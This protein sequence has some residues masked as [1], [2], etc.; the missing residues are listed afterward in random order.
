MNSSIRS[1]SVSAGT[2]TTSRVSPSLQGRH[3]RGRDQGRRRDQGSGLL[4]P[5]RRHPEVLPRSQEAVRQSQE[6][7]RARL[8]AAPL[9]LVGQIAAVDPDRFR[10]VRRLRLPRQ[11]GPDRQGV[12]RRASSISPTPS[13]PSN[14]TRSSGIFPATPSSR[15]RSTSTPRSSKVK[16]GTADGRY[17]FLKEIEGWR[18]LL[19]RNIAL[20]NPIS[21]TRAELRRA[22]HHRPHHFLRMCE[23]RGIEHYGQL[24]SALTTATASTPGSGQL[25]RKADERYNSG[26]FHFHK[27][28]PT[29]AARRSRRS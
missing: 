26:L 7:S 27:E 10:G 12:G 15:A 23:D 16:K 4:L 8:P 17:R 24:C 3:P 20:R 18:E 22:G 21:T 25:Y 13:T 11:A 29:E 6:R 19:A 1:S 9:R 28:G 14:G 5:H 2:W